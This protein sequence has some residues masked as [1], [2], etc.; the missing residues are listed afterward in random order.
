MAVKRKEH[1][2]EHKQYVKLEDEIKQKVTQA[3]ADVVRWLG[4]C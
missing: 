1:A 3:P 4:S 2:G